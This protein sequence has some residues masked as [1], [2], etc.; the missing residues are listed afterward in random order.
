MIGTIAFLEVLGELFKLWRLKRKK[1]GGYALT[2]QHLFELDE[3]LNILR[4]LDASMVKFALKN[5]QKIVLA[6]LGKTLNSGWALYW[7]PDSVNSNHIQ[8]SLDAT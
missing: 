2:R 3:D 6:P 5:G 4:K 8:T 1:F 7:L